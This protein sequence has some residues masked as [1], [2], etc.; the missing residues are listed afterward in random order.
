MKR[1]S[2]WMTGIA[3]LVMIITGCASDAELKEKASGYIRIGEANIQAGQYTQ[4]LKEL[5]E[6]EK[7]TPDDPKVHYYLGIAYERKGLVDEAVK[8]FQKA[9]A[10]KPNY[11]E[12]LNYLGT[13][14]LTRGRYDEAILSFN[15]AIANP[16]YETPS[17]ALYNM[18]RA[19]VAKGDL[20]GGYASF[21]DAIRKEPNSYLVP[22]LELNL[23]VIDYRQG[24]YGESE[25]HLMRSVERAPNLAEGQYWLGMAQME[26]RKRKEAAESFK[27]AIQL[28][29]ESEWA[30]KSR[31]NL[32]RL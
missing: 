32:N 12:A 25:K 7:L 5:L 8:E 28:A 2:S 20:K 16:L 3:V 23:G 29:P 6:A 31:E 1:A 21:S 22:V 14:Y 17:V 19:Y 18:G 24:A 13:I 10:L 30:V 15:R 26:L 27:K 9:I 11:S 4:A